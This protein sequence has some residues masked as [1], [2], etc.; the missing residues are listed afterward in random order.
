MKSWIPSPAL[1]E[2]SCG[3]SCLDSQHSGGRG[4]KQEDPRF[5]IIPD[6]VVSLRLACST[7]DHIESR[8][9]L[10][11]W[12]RRPGSSL[13][14]CSHLW[15]DH[16]LRLPWKHYHSHFQWLQIK[17]EAQSMVLQKHLLCPPSLSVDGLSQARAQ[18]FLLNDVFLFRQKFRSSESQIWYHI[19]VVSANWGSW[20]GGGWSCELGHPGQHRETQSQENKPSNKKDLN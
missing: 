7:G 3:V 10:S 14:L 16:M 4:R 12:E 18:S 5:K 20:L 9:S 8:G 13:I 15:N 1:R 19:P 2:S 17:Y 11:G 6:Y